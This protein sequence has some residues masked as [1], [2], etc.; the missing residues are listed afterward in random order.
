MLD[1]AYP[2][3]ILQESTQQSLDGIEAVAKLWSEDN[4]ESRKR[5]EASREQLLNAIGMNIRRIVTQ[6][7]VSLSSLRNPQ[8]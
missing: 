4:D 8:T 7:M 1:F 5:Y 3:I 6:S 2:R